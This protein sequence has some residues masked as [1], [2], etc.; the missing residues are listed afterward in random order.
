MRR[1]APLASYASINWVRF[2]GSRHCSAAAI[3]LSVPWLEL[4]CVRVEYR[5]HIMETSSKW[6]EGDCVAVPDINR[7]VP[8]RHKDRNLDVLR[9]S[10][11]SASRFWFRIRFKFT[12]AFPRSSNVNT[13]INCL[14]LLCSIHVVSGAASPDWCAALSNN[15][16]RRRSLG[17]NPSGVGGISSFTRFSQQ[18]PASMAKSLYWL[19]AIFRNSLSG[20]H[21]TAKI[22]KLA[23]HI[24]NIRSV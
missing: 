17:M 7:P 12:T 21:V 16:A 6:G 1:C 19:F 8:A 22:H 11:E 5:M 14:P 10:M 23:I 2:K 18:S 15:W 4:P 20:D 13:A 24:P 3:R 9:V